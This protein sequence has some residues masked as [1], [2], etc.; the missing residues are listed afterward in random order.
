MKQFTQ[1]TEIEEQIGKQVIQSCYNVHSGLGPGL[2]E[3]VYETCL[4]HELKKCGL[5]VS[6]QVLIPIKYDGII[7][8]DH[9]R[10]DLLV[11]DLVIIE[12]KAV[13]VLHP[14]H[15]AQLISYLKL[16]NLNLGFLIN[17]NVPTLK[18]GISRIRRN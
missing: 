12:L 2:L 7:L 9:L 1:T 13:E 18:E 3:R 10:L 5:Y 15:K 6:E 14:V 11:N 8:E 17:F 4:I 16:T